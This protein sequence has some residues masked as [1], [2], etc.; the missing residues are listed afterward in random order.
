MRILILVALALLTAGQARAS[1]SPIDLDPASIARKIFKRKPEPRDP[2]S[3]DELIR[4]E[5]EYRQ[6]NQPAPPTTGAQHHPAPPSSRDQRMA[7]ALERARAQG[8]G[9]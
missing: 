4:Q 3:R 9:Q 5:R 6:R 8:F 1:G 2:V 7:E